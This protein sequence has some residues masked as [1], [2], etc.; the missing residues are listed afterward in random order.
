MNKPLLATL[1][2]LLLLPTTLS[3]QQPPQ[4]QELILAQ[5]EPRPIQPIP[6]TPNRS[7]PSPQRDPRQPQPRRGVE[8]PPRQ[9]PRS[10]NARRGYVTVPVDLG[11]G[12]LAAFITGP[13]QDDQ[14][15]HTGLRLSVAAVVN[16]KVIRENWESIPREYR[17]MA[18]G[19]QEVRVKPLI[20]ALIPT[21]LY[22]SPKIYDTG[23]YGATWELL[24]FGLP[25]IT[26]PVRFTL[27][28]GLLFTYLYT[29]SDTLRS[30]THF[31]R[32]GLEFKADLEIPITDDFLISFG[33]AS[34]LYP[35]QLVGGMPWEF[36]PL[37]QTIFHIGQA[38]IQAHIRFPYTTKL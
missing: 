26:D 4:E 32:P 7:Q 29:H 3:A 31:V 19:I 37:G 22:I 36:L 10:G 12:P 5:S 23:A 2:S 14:L 35:P 17:Q 1:T 13:I 33:W 27:S 11:I 9:Q 20:A 16:Q 34:Q 21:A 15:F 18:R 30:P 6:R 8:P 38:Y 28:T 25:L 24:G